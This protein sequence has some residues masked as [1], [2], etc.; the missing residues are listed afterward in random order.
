MQ[1]QPLPIQVT[2]TQGYLASSSTI[3]GTAATAGSISLTPGQVTTGFAL[4]LTPRILPNGDIIF[5]YALDLSSLNSIQ[6][7]SS[8]GQEIQVPN[9]SSRRFVQRAQIHTGDTLILSGYEQTN[10]NDQGATGLFSWFRGTSSDHQI[11]FITIEAN[12]L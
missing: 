4:I 5:Q 11:I 10:N 3:V 12:V 9:V 2:S 6:T 7:I 8:G 1:G